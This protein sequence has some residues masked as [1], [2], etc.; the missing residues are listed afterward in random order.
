MRKSPAPIKPSA[1]KALLLGTLLAAS[2][3][4][5]PITYT[6]NETIMHTPSQGV[7]LWNLVTLDLIAPQNGDNLLQ[8]L[9]WGNSGS[10][11]NIPPTLFLAGVNT[12]GNAPEPATLSVFGA[13][14]A[15][16]WLR[17]RAKRKST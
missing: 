4:A 3:Q 12:P 11:A 14:L 5:A 8:F 6:V 7:T 13:G 17:R 15:G 10:N 16:V 1:V 2:A 9:A